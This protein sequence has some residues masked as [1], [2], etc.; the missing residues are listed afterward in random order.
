MAIRTLPVTAS[1]RD[2]RS[3]V[4]E[5]SETIAR[6]R[7]AEALEM[8][9][10]EGTWSAELLQRTIQGYGVPEYDESLLDML[11]AWEVKEFKI[12]SI[13]GRNDV[14]DFIEKHIVVDRH[15]L[16]GL[17]P[18]QYVGMVHYNDVP[19][20]GYISDLTARFHIKKVDQSRMTLEFLDI[21]VM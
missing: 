11:E 4:V 19:L 17:D 14:T 18:T 20:S 3:L 10:F 7:F 21:H 6:G 9:P 13:Y 5:W 16:Y 8:F 15:H 1:D 2:I 12:T